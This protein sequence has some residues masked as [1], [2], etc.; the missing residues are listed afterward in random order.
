MLFDSRDHCA[1]FEPLVGHFGK[2]PP[3]TGQ[4]ELTGLVVGGPKSYENMVKNNP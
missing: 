3:P 4:P 1:S 2:G